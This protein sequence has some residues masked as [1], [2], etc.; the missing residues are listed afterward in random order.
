MGMSE[1]GAGSIFAV[2]LGMARQLRVGRLTL[3]LP[4]RS[5]HGF[6]GAEPGP[7]G[8]L[9]LHRARVV[10]RF[11][12]G[13]A[14]GFADAYLDGDWDSPD[15]AALLQV[16]AL[17]EQSFAEHYYGKAWVRALARVAHLLRPN[18]R[19]GS[20]KNIHAHYDLGN[21]FYARWLDP[22]MTYSSAVFER[23]DA[24][25]EEAQLTK[26]RRLAAMTGVRPDAHVL[27]IGC[28]WGSFA[29]LAARE[30]GAKV[31]G[32]TISDAQAEFARRRIFEAGLAERV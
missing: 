16:L 29:E 22:S 1:A 15:L 26:L 13:G 23:P 20:K 2:L 18:T 11:L 6:A 31:T 14:N 24:T 25:L 4:D 7:S 5:R 10:R 17:N 30:F 9:V 28:G 32:L 21:Q 8:E 27:E 12:T 3:V 19:K